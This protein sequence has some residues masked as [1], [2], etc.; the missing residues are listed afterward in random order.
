MSRERG[1]EKMRRRPVP[2]ALLMTAVLVAG[3]FPPA[4][5][6]LG[7][8]PCSGQERPMRRFQQAQQTPQEGITLNFQNVA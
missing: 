4:S 3:P 8:A 1:G 5:G 2:V 6:A 7:A